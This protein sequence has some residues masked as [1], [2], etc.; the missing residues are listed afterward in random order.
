MTDDVAPLAEKKKPDLIIL[1][2][3]IEPAASINQDITK[4]M[5]T[6]NDRLSI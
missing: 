1:V 3:I 2:P 6:S 5:I 4:Y